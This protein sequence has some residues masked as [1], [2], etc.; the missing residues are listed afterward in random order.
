M[1]KEFITLT[2]YATFTHYLLILSNTRKQG[3]IFGLLL[4]IEN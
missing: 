4:K 1:D 2:I 3:T